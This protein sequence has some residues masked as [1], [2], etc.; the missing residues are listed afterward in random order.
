MDMDGLKCKSKRGIKDK[1]LSFSS[2]TFVFA[3][4]D[5]DCSTIPVVVEE[6]CTTTRHSQVR[7]QRSTNAVVLCKRDHSARHARML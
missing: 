4:G 2:V 1:G 3:K 5:V 6:G 7:A